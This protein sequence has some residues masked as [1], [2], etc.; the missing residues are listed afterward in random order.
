MGPQAQHVA[1][2]IPTKVGI[3]RLAD[4]IPT[5]VGMTSIAGLF[6]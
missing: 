3:Q 5:F 6:S 4:W 1:T 2:V